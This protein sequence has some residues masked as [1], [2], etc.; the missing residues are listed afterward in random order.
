MLK[1]LITA[2]ALSLTFAA[3]PA[4]AASGAATGPYEKWDN[5]TRS[6]FFNDDMSLRSNDEIGQSWEGLSAEQQASIRQ[7]CQNAFPEPG[8]SDLT[9]QTA[10]STGNPVPGVAD[11]K[12]AC[13]TIGSM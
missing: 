4:L 3:A 2:A 1:T 9:D 8:S 7:D 10:D 5:S 11:Q 6:M 12:A 13:D